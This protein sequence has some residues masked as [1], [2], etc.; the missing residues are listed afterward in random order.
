MRAAEDAILDAPH[1]AGVVARIGGI[2]GPGRER[3]LRTAV[4]STPVSARWTNRIH[5]DDA[6]RALVHLATAPPPLV[7]DVVNVV[8]REPARKHDVVSFI[9]QELGVTAPP[10]D[11]DDTSQ[12]KRVDGTRLLTTGFTHEYPT[13]REGYRDIIAARHD[14]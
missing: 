2:Y 1:V 6:A 10:L 8:D 13:Y 9:A 4:R 14:T 7:P 3:L 12:G 5:A 11:A